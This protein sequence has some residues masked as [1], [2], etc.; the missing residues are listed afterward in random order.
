MK[1]TEITSVKNPTAIEVSELKKK[2]NKDGFLLE[3][4]KFIRDLP[5]GSIIKVFTT[6]TEKYA[7]I[8][9]KSEDAFSV[10]QSVMDKITDS[11]SQSSLCAVVRKLNAE[12]P[13]KL[14]L[15]DGIQDPGNVGTMIRT[16]HA[17]GFGVV[18]GDGCANPFLP[19]A[20]RSSVG[21]VASAYVE[22]AELCEYIKALKND[23]FE[24][25]GTALDDKSLPL[26]K[27]ESE[28]F[29]AVIGSEGNGISPSVRA[30]CD[31]TYYIPI[32]NVESLN[33]SVA[34]AIVIYANA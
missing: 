27:N 33:A 22:K 10:S 34:A 7:D 32:K 14:L 21:A 3:G 29:A 4:D 26:C 20:V 23:G 5:N 30:L 8:I 9:A 24:V 16:A 13:E 15:L 11:V 2:G 17:F 19:K 31:K 1:I 28:H 25:C 18:C 6:D 12:R